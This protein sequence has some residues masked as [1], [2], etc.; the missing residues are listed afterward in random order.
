VRSLARQARLCQ[1]VIYRINNKT[2]TTLRLG[3]WAAGAASR[4]PA[5]A[6]AIPGYVES[7]SILVDD[8]NAGRHHAAELARRAA[9][10][11]IEVRQVDISSIWRNA[12]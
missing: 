2:F 4:L 12:A 6:D 1:L 8:D 3:A 10:H 5:L 7:L 11:G 9:A